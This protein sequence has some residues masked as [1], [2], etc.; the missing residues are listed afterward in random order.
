MQTK[1]AFVSLIALEGQSIDI[2]EKHLLHPNFDCQATA[3]VRL[4]PK[5]FCFII[6]TSR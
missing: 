2:F 4:R 5:K 6:I 1:Y 3:F